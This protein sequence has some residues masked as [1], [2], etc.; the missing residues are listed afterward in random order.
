MLLPLQDNPL[1]NGTLIHLYFYNIL[2]KLQTHQFAIPDLI[3]MIIE[4]EEVH[5]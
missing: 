5:T 1:M 4:T 3:T 2:D